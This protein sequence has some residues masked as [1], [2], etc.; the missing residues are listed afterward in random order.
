VIVFGAHPDDADFSA[1]GTAILFSQMGHKVKFVSMTNGN[2]GHH[3]LNEEECRAAHFAEMKRVAELINIEYDCLDYTDGELT[4]TIENRKAVI[5]MICDWKADIV[6][7]HR[8]NDY[9]PDH[10]Y[11][12][13]IVQ[14]AAYMISVPKMVP[15]G[16]PLLKAPV[17]LYMADRFTKPT[18]FSPDIVIDITPVMEKKIDIVDAHPSQVYG[19]MPW[20]GGYEDKVPKDVA[21]RRQ[22]L[23]ER[24][25]SRGDIEKY[26]VAALNWYSLAQLAD[27]RFVEC[28]EICEYGHVPSKER[29]KEL[30]PMLPK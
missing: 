14:D 3:I 1:G 30:F 10:R 7:T 22:H 5:K 8:T 21:G 13:I 6:M 17:F 4:P 15:D 11:T 28:Y 25:L 29:I 27:C 9:H 2:K 16:E 20:I 18:P 23:V 26:K 19:W 24:F 12:S